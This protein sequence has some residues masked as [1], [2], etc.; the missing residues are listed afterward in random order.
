VN[1]ATDVKNMSAFLMKGIALGTQPDLVGSGLIR[2]AGGWSAG[3]SMRKAGQFQKSDERM[4]G[5][6]EFVERVLS[7]ARESMKTRYSLSAQGIS[8]ADILSSED[9][10]GDCQYSRKQRRKNCP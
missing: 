6:G 5:D 2:S 3:R 1:K 8:I 4:S 10:P 7:D 9:R